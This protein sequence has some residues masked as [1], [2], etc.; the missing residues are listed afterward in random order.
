MIWCI[1]FHYPESFQPEP[2]GGDTEEELMGTVPG[3]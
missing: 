1:G 3:L 2:P